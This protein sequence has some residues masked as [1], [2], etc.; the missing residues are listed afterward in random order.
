MENFMNY[1][2]SKSSGYEFGPFGDY[3]WHLRKNKDGNIAFKLRKAPDFGFYNACVFSA[4]GSDSDVS[5]MKTIM[6][7]YRICAKDHCATTWS[8]F[9]HLDCPCCS[10]NSI[11]QDTS[12]Q[13]ELDKCSLC[14][15]PMARCMIG[16]SKKVVLH[17]NH[18]VCGSCY[19][20]IQSTWDAELNEEVIK[21]PF[22]R[23]SC[24]F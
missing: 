18:V 14:A 24:S 21:C 5:E 23:K 17:D 22:C 15:Q 19:D 20:G 4:P 2:E 7:S 10:L 8:I 11:I 13:V 12:N 3:F 9:D 16:S 6:R 1:L